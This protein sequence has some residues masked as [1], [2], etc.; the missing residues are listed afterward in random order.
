MKNIA[1]IKQW[2]ASKDTIDILDDEEHRFEIRSKKEISV[3]LSP[4]MPGNYA[5]VLFDPKNECVLV[6]QITDASKYGHIV[7]AIR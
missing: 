5:R 1:G 7:W 3:S 4:I 2:E 6:E